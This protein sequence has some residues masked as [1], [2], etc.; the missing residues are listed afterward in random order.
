MIDLVRPRGFIPVHG[1]L[2]HLTR[3]ADLARGAGVPEVLVIENGETAVVSPE[4][5]VRGAAVPVGRIATHDG[6]EIADAVLREREV[7]ARG[8]VAHVTLV[9]DKKGKLAGPP[10]VVGRSLFDEATTP[11][12]LRAAAREVARAIEARP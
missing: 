4:G 5:L 1:T 12:A 8:G 2:H 6:I 3:H 7:L 11:G 9:V 10:I